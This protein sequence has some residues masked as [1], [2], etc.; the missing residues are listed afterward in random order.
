MLGNVEWRAFQIVQ[1]AVILRKYKGL[2]VNGPPNCHLR[3]A[4][5]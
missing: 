4:C 3:Q 2:Y 5:K 1:M